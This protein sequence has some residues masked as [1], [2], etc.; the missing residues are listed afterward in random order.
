MVRVSRPCI[1]LPHVRKPWLSRFRR[2]ANCLEMEGLY[3]RRLHY[4]WR[5]TWGKMSA[6]TQV[7]IPRTLAPIFG[8]V[9]VHTPEVG[10]TRGRWVAFRSGVNPS[11]CRNHESN[12]GAAQAIQRVRSAL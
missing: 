6:K 3:G 8:M 4:R 11:F 10:A 2:W 1:T 7:F 5:R 9:G 12:S